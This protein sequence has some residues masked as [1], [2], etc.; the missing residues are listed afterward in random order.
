MFITQ[1]D[2]LGAFTL[3]PHFPSP[4]GNHRLRSAVF[5]ALPSLA[6]LRQ[7]NHTVCGL[8]RPAP[9][10]ERNVFEICP[11]RGSSSMAYSF[12]LLN[13]IPARIVFRAVTGLRRGV[14]SLGETHGD[15]SAVILGERGC[16][17]GESMALLRVGMSPLQPLQ[18]YWPRTGHFTFQVFMFSFLFFIVKFLLG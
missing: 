15:V 12:L 3:N 16:W 18:A 5:R 4:L 7:W 6:T 13:G 2:P 1:Y 10:T 8:I 14:R 11:C 17:W 9:S